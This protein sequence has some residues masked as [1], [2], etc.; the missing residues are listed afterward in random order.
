V[1]VLIRVAIGTC[2]LCISSLGIAD[3][4]RIA[5]AANFY[6]ALNKIKQQ[7]EKEYDYRL[8]IIRGSTGKL[9]AQIIHGAPYDVF[10]AADI[11]RPELLEEKKLAIANSRFTYAVGQLA[12]WSTNNKQNAWSLL[13]NNTFNKLAIANPKTA[14]YGQAAIDVMK[15]LNIYDKIKNKLVYGENIA[16]A[17]QFVQSGSAD[18]GFVAHAHVKSLADNVWLA[19][20][21]SHSTLEQQMVILSSTKNLKPAQQFSQFMQRDDIKAFIQQQGYETS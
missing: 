19:D 7:F 17:F 18:I 10:L 20:K 21:T 13:E 9:Y 8:D 4:L 14:P 1:I 6:P 5:V 11:K 2:L 3:T 16:Q 15:H 12:L